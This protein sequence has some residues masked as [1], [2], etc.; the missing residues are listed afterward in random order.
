MVNLA[1]GREIDGQ[2]LYADL[3]T[4]L[5]GT[6]TPQLPP[7]PPVQA[8]DTNTVTAAAQ[9]FFAWYDAL[10]GRQLSD[11]PAWAANRFE[12]QIGLGARTTDG[13]LVL[14]AAEFDSGELDW[15]DFDITPGATVGATADAA[16]DP[17]STQTYLPT[18]VRFYGAAEAGYWAFEDASIELGAVEASAEDI[19]TMLVVDFAVRYGN[20][21]FLIPLCLDVGTVT[22]ITQLMVT[23]TFGITIPIPPVSQSGQP[24]R[25]FEHTVTGTDQRDTALTLFPTPASPLQSPAFETVTLIRDELADRCWALEQTVL[26][27]TGLPVDRSA[28]IAQGRPLPPPPNTPTADPVRVLSYQ[29]RSELA[30]NWYPLLPATQPPSALQLGKVDPLPDQP[31]QPAPTTRTLTELAELAR[32]AQADA[33]I[34]AEEIT[35]DGLQITRRWRYARGHDGMQYLWIARRATPVARVQSPDLRFDQATTPAEPMPE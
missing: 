4:H 24:M 29:L 22:R 17:P 12:Y 23:D 19:A 2:A 13:E 16:P 18:P 11:T 28:Q 33:A 8:A 27:N 31:P 10:S 9:S 15:H 25:L 32:L 20:D 7:D 26:G 1:R 5:R 6:T 35:R 34:P 14:S 21:F 30:D 3:D